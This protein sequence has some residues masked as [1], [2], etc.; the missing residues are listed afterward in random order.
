M[1]RHKSKS[2]CP[3]LEKFVHWSLSC[4]CWWFDCKGYCRNSIILIQTSCHT[5]E[6]LG[7]LL[8]KI[9]VR[10]IEAGVL[11]KSPPQSVL[12]LLNWNCVT[13]L[14]VVFQVRERVGFAF[15]IYFFPFCD[16]VFAKVVGSSV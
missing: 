16:K 12:L 11:S 7:I 14:C 10:T 8:Q 4:G 1:L 9:T 15:Q 3:G 2:R 5:F 13:M 6:L